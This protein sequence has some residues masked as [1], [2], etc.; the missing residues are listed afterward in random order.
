[1][2][3]QAVSSG[4]QS[5]KIQDDRIGAMLAKGTIDRDLARNQKA[6]ALLN[7][8]TLK[9][10]LE[11]Y[12]DY[13]IEGGH[14]PRFFKRA[15]PSIEC[16]IACVNCQWARHFITNKVPSK[17]RILSVGPDA[18]QTWREDVPE[19]LNL[20]FDESF[21]KIDVM[22]QQ[23]IVLMTQDYVDASFPNMGIQAV[24]RDLESSTED[25][26]LMHRVLL[27]DLAQSKLDRLNGKDTKELKEE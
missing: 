16:L 4:L 7:S 15:E 12:P 23:T 9:E 1:M 21:L 13:K 24:I 11:A 10:F 6:A 8:D 25:E 20:I 26:L 17:E 5:L 22:L 3:V 19:I 18:T 27:I 14:I 2:A